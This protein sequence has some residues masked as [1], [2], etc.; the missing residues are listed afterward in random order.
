MYM[1]ILYD[2]PQNVKTLKYKCILNLKFCCFVRYTVNNIKFL[3]WDYLLKCL[4]EC[5]SGIGPCSYMRTGS[6][7]DSSFYA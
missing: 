6:S 3:K 7:I 1:F 5:Y 2:Q 4:S